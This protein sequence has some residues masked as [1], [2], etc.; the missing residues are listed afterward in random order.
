MLGAIAFELGIVLLLLVAN[1]V[2]AASE[3]ALV[4]ARRSRLEAQ[5]AAGDRRAAQALKLSE[6]PDRL[7]ATVQIGITLIGTF[8]SAFG[9]AKI[10]DILAV[11]LKN[12]PAVAEYAD[13]LALAIVVLIITYLS[14]IVGELVPKRLALLHAD[15]V[16]R[17]FAPLLIWL[18]ALTRPFVWFLT[19]SSNLI[20]RLLRQTQQPDA[21]ITED[22]ILYMTRAGRA[23][24]TVALHEE[25]LIERVFDFSDHTARML[26]TPR[27]AVV[28]VRIDTPLVETAR[29]AIEHGYSRIPVYENDSLDHA[30]GT[31]N[32]KDLLPTLIE[33]KSQ[34]LA[35]ILRPPTFVLEHEPVSKLLTRFRRNGTHMALVVDEYGQ[36]AGILTLEDILE[37]LVGDIRDEYDMSEEQKVVKRDDG[38]WLIDG[39]EAFATIAHMLKQEERADSTDF[40]TLAGFVIA[41][42]GRLPNAGDSVEWGAYIVEVVDMDGRRV[43]KVLVRP[44][45]AA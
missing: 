17:T 7:L 6:H 38:S 2:F 40:V 39:S 28:A 15:G 10:G 21:S 35:D 19:I 27:P 34:T 14:L 44:K 30:L 31:V 42:L 32:I 20:L 3:L 1:G 18:S 26:M 16:A 23:G 8:A 24:G 29:L 37:E 9:G 13:T 25:R 22:D 5:A 4:S 36:I 43:D 11:A 41:Q 45:A 33:D 12:V